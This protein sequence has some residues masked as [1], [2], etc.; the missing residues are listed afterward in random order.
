VASA[1]PADARSADAGPAVADIA[2][3]LLGSTSEGARRTP[4]VLAE[5]E[6]PLDAATR[7]LIKRTRIGALATA[8][9]RVRGA[10]VGSLVVA[11]RTGRRFA[12]HDLLLLSALADQVALVVENDR[13]EAETTR[14]QYEAG[15]L[16]LV[17]SLIG[18]RLDP[19]S[20]GQRIAE[21]VLGL[22]GVHSAVIRLFQP[23]GALAAIALAGRAKEY[24]EIGDRIPAGLG[25]VGR[26]AVEG[27]PI[28][29]SD[30]RVDGRFEQSPTLRARNVAVGVSPGRGSGRPSTWKGNPQMSPARGTWLIADA[31]ATPGIAPT[32]VSIA[33]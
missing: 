9:I 20:A 21:S 1:V 6:C 12:D 30:I 10:V 32:L 16:A 33:S 2:F 19:L 17:A 27:R 31:L 5:R 23:D 24:A 4:D 22:L 11:D 15:E 8:P 25:L 29:T 14:Q 7:A 3:S 18:E 26:A 28:W 13:L